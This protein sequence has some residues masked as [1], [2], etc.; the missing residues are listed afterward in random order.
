MKLKLVK[1][2]KVKGKRVLLRVGFDVPIAN[3]LVSDDTRIRESLPTIEYLLEQGSRIILLSHLGRPQGK[4][5]AKYSQ[6]SV[7]VRLRE[8]LG[9]HK[10]TFISESV[11]AQ[12]LS[13]GIPAP[14][15]GEIVML[16]NIRFCAGEETN[17]QMFAESLARLG[18][19]YVDDA[20][21]NAHRDH[22]SMAALAECLP[23]YAGFLMA[24]EVKAL[25]EVVESPQ[26]PFVAI[27]GGAKISTKLN[28]ITTLLK[29][30]DFLLLGGALA[31]TILKAQ[32]MQVGK[33]LI[34]EQ[35]VSVA[36]S[37]T[38]TDNRLK[39]PV[40]V[41]AAKEIKEGAEI[42][43]RAVGSL[44]S[45]EIIL[46]I[47]ADTVQLYKMII[48]KAGTVVWN[49]PMGYFEI[50]K[51]AGGTYD[52]AKIISDQPKVQSVLGGGE[53]V[54]AIN[55]LGIKDKFSFVSTG[56]GAMLEFLEGKILPGIKPL[57]KK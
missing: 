1:E 34:E 10:V 17:D 32:G 29:K 15:P 2:A 47:G 3:G 48:E 4:V 7:A 52:I 12:G 57:I 11:T 40:D 35:M 31:N 16:E 26:R 28:L 27:I 50:E 20:F 42:Y 23:A 22:A 25:S 36:K 37:F 44:L 45:D 38:L 14:E 18:D 41:L 51:F 5:D 55:H 9:D 39:I 49:G 21:S 33:S 19:I 46:D 54:D 30:V 43:K 56:G 24:R 8:L 13:A 6:A 53:T